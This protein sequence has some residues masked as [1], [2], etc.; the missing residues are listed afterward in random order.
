MAIVIDKARTNL[1]SVTRAMAAFTQPTPRTM[2]RAFDVEASTVETHI[3]S[4]D[5]DGTATAPG[6]TDNNAQIVDQ[7][8]FFLPSS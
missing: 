1:V 6:N 4:I 5:T 3:E 2:D 7:S 8:G